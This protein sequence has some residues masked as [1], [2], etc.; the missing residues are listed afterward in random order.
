M[1]FDRRAVLAGGAASAVLAGCSVASPIKPV[2]ATQNVRLLGADNIFDLSAGVETIGTGYGWSEGP[3]W[4]GERARLY[5]SDVPGNKVYE[6]DRSDGTRI[7]LDPSGSDVTEGFREP[8]ANGLLFDGGDTLLLCNHGLRRVET[9]DLQTGTRRAL[10]ERFEGR[11]YNSPNDLVRADDGTIFF[12]DPPYGLEGLDASPLKEMSVNGVYRRRA[13]GT[14]TRLL[15]DMTRP[16]G[17]AL[18]PDGRKLYVTQSDPDAPILRELTMSDTGTVTGD[19]VLYDF[20]S[21]MS[22]DSP[23]LPDGLAVAHTGEILVAGPGGVIAISPDGDLLSRLHVGSAAANCAFGE[24]DR[25]TLF[26]TAHDRVLRVRTRLRG[27]T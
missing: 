9:V 24:A 3:T 22:D 27:L 15:D 12:T 2:V 11:R 18:S 23:G 13:D 14:V 26:V 1:T 4:D 16:N 8:G 6:W 17:V 21:L 19:R 10:T 5:F 7:K 25:R 20:A